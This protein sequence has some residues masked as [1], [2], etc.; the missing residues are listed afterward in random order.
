MASTIPSKYSL[1][2]AP[3]ILKAEAYWFVLAM[4]G[5][6]SETLPPGNFDPLEVRSKELAE[7]PGAWKGG[8]SMIMLLRYKESPV[9][10]CEYYTV[11]AHS[12]FGGY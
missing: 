4:F 6:S 7:E 1:V 2:P 5:K 3:W 9:G 11:H 12:H 10:P 8:P